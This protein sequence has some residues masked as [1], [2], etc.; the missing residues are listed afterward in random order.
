MFAIVLEIFSISVSMSLMIG[1]FFSSSI[2]KIINPPGIKI[3]LVKSFLFIFKISF[4]IFSL[5]ELNFIQPNF[6]PSFEL[7]DIL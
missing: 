2:F 1:A 4:F 3:G 5:K 7:S 6:P